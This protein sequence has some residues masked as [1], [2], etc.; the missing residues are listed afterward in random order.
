MSDCV[1]FENVRYSI[2]FLAVSENLIK[3]QKARII[4]HHI[5]CLPSVGSVFFEM[6]A[7]RDVKDADANG[8]RPVG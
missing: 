6:M 2:F 8:C 4:Q 5:D 7:D 1:S 3:K